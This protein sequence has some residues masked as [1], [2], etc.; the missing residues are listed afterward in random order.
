MNLSRDEFLNYFTGLKPTQKESGSASRE[1][2]EI[3]EE[4]QV[5]KW[6]EKEIGPLS[7]QTL[8]LPESPISQGKEGNNS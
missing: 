4:T 1:G 2:R 8:R 3:K 7:R 6:G 5:P